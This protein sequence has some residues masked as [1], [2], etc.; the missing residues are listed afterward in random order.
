MSIK[1]LA[2]NLCNQEPGRGQRHALAAGSPIV[3]RAKGR[4]HTRAMSYQVAPDAG[5]PFTITVKGRVKWT[6]DQLCQA[7]LTGCTPRNNP[8]SRLSAYVKT[9]RDLGV[10]IETIREPHEGDYPGFHGRYVLCA[11]VTQA[12]GGAA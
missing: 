2:R 6:L 5:D 10:P 8:A 4:G 7:G 1:D 12:K 3:A 9:L 11:T